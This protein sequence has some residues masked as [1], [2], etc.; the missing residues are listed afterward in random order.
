M[1]KSKIPDFLELAVQRGEGRWKRNRIRNKYKKYTVLRTL[2]SK[3][4]VMGD[5]HKIG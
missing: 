5:G 1:N 2:E 4:K 3:K